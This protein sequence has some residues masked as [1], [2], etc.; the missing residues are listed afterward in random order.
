LDTSDRTDSSDSKAKHAKI[1]YITLELTELGGNYQGTNDNLNR[2]FAMLTTYES[3]EGYKHYHVN[4]DNSYHTIT[5]VFNPR[6]N[7]NKLTIQLKLPDGTPYLFG[8]VDETG[9]DRPSLV[10]LSFRITCL[11]K[12]LATTFYAKAVY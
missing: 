9:D 5:K 12:N 1:P 10:K 2:A 3:I 8:A 7:L 11:Q 6:I 4:S